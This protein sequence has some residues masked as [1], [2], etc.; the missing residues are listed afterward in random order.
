MDGFPADFTVTNLDDSGPGSLRW[1]I[2]CANRHPGPDLIHFD[3]GLRGTIT[4]TSPLPIIG[5]L[6][7]DG[8]GNGQIKISGSGATRVFLVT[9]LHAEVAMTGLTIIKGKATTHGGGIVNFGV[10]PGSC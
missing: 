4:L 2:Q 5:G 3:P 10:A 1:A 8:P 6:R 7:I 9:G